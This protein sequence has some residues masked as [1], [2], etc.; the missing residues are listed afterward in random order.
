ML[1][2]AFVRSVLLNDELSAAV[3]SELNEVR[4]GTFIKCSLLPPSCRI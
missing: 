2:S 4:R 3:E 1:L